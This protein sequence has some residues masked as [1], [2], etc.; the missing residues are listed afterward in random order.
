MEQEQAPTNEPVVTEDAAAPGA[1]DTAAP[2]QPN[3][4]ELG[5]LLEDARNKADENWNQ[6]MRLSA[7]LDNLRK[8]Q[9]RELENAHR[10]A[11]ERF[12]AELLGV[13]D[14]LELGH[15][16][17]LE[18]GVNVEKL[19]EGNELTL[20]L[21]GDVMTKFGVEQ[22]APQGQ[23]FNPEL[24][25]AMSL[26]PRNDVPPNTVTTVI[27]KGYTLNGRLVRPAMV[28]VSQAAGGIDEQ[29]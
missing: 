21:L 14:S 25:Q 17:A 15:N 9:A 6:V 4:E 20:K 27:Q 22:L 2:S 1:A 7:E 10:F 12:V 3:T 8:R 29:A 5:R 24:H 16:A 13:W 19:R 23:P 28:M 11:L 18:A 26:Q